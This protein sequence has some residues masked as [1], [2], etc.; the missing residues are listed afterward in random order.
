MTPHSLIPRLSIVL[1]VIFLLDLY[2]FSGVRS[3]FSSVRIRFIVS[4]CYWAITLVFYL[5]A[6]YVFLSFSR[7]QGPSATPVK[8]AMSLF[9]FLYVPKLV[10]FF[11]FGVEDIY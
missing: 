10:L 7:E 4:F 8:S 6:I 2:I 5:L 3:A 1:C 11:F 9:I